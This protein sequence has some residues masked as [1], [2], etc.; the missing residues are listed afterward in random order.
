MLCDSC[1]HV[2][3]NELGEIIE[4]E[5]LDEDQTNQKVTFG[6]EE[7]K[8]Y[9]PSEAGS[10]SPTFEEAAPEVDQDPPFSESSVRI[11]DR[12]YFCKKDNPDHPGRHCCM[13][14]SNINL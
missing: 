14:P 1:I 7:T 11:L 10:S 4:E 12:C 9:T 6:G 8:L 13:K 5:R 3:F 2:K